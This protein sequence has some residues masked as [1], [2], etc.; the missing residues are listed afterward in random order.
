MRF[1]IAAAALALIGCS[2]ARIPDSC[3]PPQQYHWPQEHNP[4]LLTL[5]Y[6]SAHARILQDVDNQPGAK[7][8][9]WTYQ[10]PAFSFALKRTENLDFYMRFSVH[11]RTFADTGPVTLSI[12]VNGKMIDHPRIDA[13][14]ERE[15]SYPVP[16]ILLQMKNPVI[17]QID[18]DPVWPSDGTKLG[19]LLWAM[20]FAQ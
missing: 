8:P 19:I 11:S 5:G 20:G 1:R 2:C 15:Y 6:R 10:H 3:S 13:P 7:G 16:S 14:G 9:V 4:P 17:V 18:V 12:F